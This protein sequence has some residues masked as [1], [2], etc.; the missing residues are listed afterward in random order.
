MKLSEEQ[1]AY[2]KSLDS[3]KK[4]R[5]FMLDCLV[6]SV[7]GESAEFVDRHIFENYAN[8]LLDKEITLETCQS[9]KTKSIHHSLYELASKFRNKEKQILDTFSKEK[10][11]DLVQ[12]GTIQISDMIHS[13]NRKI[14]K[15][16]PKPKG[17]MIDPEKISDFPITKVDYGQFE[18]E[19]TNQDP[20]LPFSTTSTTAPR[21]FTPSGN[22]FKDSID[23]GVQAISAINEA[24]K[25]ANEKK[26][27]LL[28][29][30]ML[31]VEEFEK[32]IKTKLYARGFS[33]SKI[34]NNRGLIGATIQETMSKVNESA[35]S[36]KKYTE[37]DMRNAF[38]SGR[39]KTKVPFG[40]Y[41]FNTFEDCI[42]TFKND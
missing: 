32:E 9:L 6:E 39:Y 29:F 13:E 26:D 42:K 22:H 34:L 35:N 20:I 19:K 5:K 16:F 17:T 38:H 2:L 4:R 11:L 18:N 3:K 24:Y 36:E 30:D 28:K 25:K 10:L 15:L 7:I 21:T 33:I 12:N 37:E 27:E 1:I 40:G 23:L 31:E 14:E 41:Y 8:D